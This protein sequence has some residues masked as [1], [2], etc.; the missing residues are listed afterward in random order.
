MKTAKWLSIILSLCLI[1]GAAGCNKSKNK[2]KNVEDNFGV[3]ENRGIITYNDSAADGCGWKIIIDSMELHP[4]T[5]LD[6]KYKVNNSAVYVRYN[7]L[8]SMWK[9]SQ[10]DSTEFQ[11]I[12]VIEI[13]PIENSK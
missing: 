6:E 13:I 7:L 11:E 1:I 12:K 3:F 10:T 9:C 2:D 8:P 5:P 4:T